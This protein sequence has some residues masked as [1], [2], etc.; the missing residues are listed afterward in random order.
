[1]KGSLRPLVQAVLLVVVVNALV[2]LLARW[3]PVV[4][5][6]RWYVGAA[7][8]LLGGVFLQA[9]GVRSE[10]GTRGR[11]GWNAEHSERLMQE[12]RAQESSGL[13]LALLGGSMLVVGWLL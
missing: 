13:L 2:L 1:M 3:F 7:L 9:G 12:K 11:T 8:L 4:G 10:I 6:L 5:T